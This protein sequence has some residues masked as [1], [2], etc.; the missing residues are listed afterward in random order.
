MACTAGTN[1]PMLIA[2]Q[3]RMNVA[4]SRT[5]L[6]QMLSTKPSFRKEEENGTTGSHEC[7][8]ADP[9]PLGTSAGLLMPISSQG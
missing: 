8:I 5:S 4:C 7:G 3:V 2:C 1:L 9:F 6:R